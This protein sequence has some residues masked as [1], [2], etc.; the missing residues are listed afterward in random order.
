MATVWWRECE[1]RRNADFLT[2][3][4]WIMGLDDKLNQILDR[5]E[6]SDDED[7]D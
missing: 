3:M 1:E 7:A 4:A 2:L 5:L 6:V